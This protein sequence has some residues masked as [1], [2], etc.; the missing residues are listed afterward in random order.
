MLS[1]QKTL[2]YIKN[3]LALPFNKI[4]LTDDKIWEYLID[5]TIPEFSSYWPDKRII[6]YNFTDL[7]NHAMV[8]YN[9]YF[10]D[11]EG[12]S[13]LSVL[14]IIPSHDVVVQKHPYIGI[15]NFEQ[16]V[17]Y[18]ESIE[19]AGL[20]Y[21]FGYYTFS[22][23]FIHPNIIRVSG[24]I[25]TTSAII[26]ERVHPSDLYTIDGHMEKYFLK[27]CLADIKILLGNIRTKFQN[28]TTPYGE[29]PIN[30][31]IKD[32]GMTEKRE[33]IEILDTKV[34]NLTIVYG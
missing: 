25:P 4:E 12:N 30:A 28:L 13:V 20:M 31:G 23:E 33:V 8:P 2:R 5:F 6:G 10:R 7:T 9:Y 34:P 32:E 14:E 16:S 24:A 21:R 1:K 18:V 29:I 15:L 26:Y 22:F 17:P 19:E 11:P 27:F 3:T